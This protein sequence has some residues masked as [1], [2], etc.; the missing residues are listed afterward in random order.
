MAQKDVSPEKMATRAFL[1]T[2][3]GLLVYVATVFVFIL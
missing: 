3:A 1:I 2:I